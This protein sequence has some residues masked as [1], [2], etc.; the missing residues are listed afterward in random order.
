MSSRDEREVF[1]AVAVD[2]EFGTI[3]WPATSISIPT[4]SAE[5]NPR[6]PDKLFPGE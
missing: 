5:T 6:P 2:H 4:F 3:A 1:Q